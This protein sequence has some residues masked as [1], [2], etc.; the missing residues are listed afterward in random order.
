MNKIV[1]IHAQVKRKG[2]V[3][4]DKELINHLLNNQIFKNNFELLYSIDPSPNEHFL[5]YNYFTLVLYSELFDS[6]EW[7]EES[8]FYEMM[9]YRN[10]D[11]IDYKIEVKRLED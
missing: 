2:K 9:I 4:V 8:P 11:G 7:Y 3:K 10:E 1:S 6:I 5:D